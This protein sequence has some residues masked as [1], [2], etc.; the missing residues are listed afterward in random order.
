MSERSI[1][2]GLLLP[3]FLFLGL[4]GSLL[5]WVGCRHSLVVDEAAHLAAGVYDWE[6]A[7]FD[8]YRVNPPLV[9]CT[10]AVPVVVG[11]PE[12]NWGGNNASAGSRP[13]WILGANFL[14]ANDRGNA[15]WF[16]YFVL[17]RWA[18]LPFSV[19]G[20][21]VCYRWARELYGPLAG[22]VTLILWCFSPNMIAW[23]STI[24][25][26]VAASALGVAAGYVFWRWLKNP[27][28]RGAVVAGAVLGVAQL[29]KTTWV[30]LFGLW[31]LIL[32]IWRFGGTHVSR[33]H[34][35]A[36]RQMI[37][38]PWRRD[39]AQMAAI[40]LVGIYAI[41]LGYG[42]DGSFRN[43]GAYTFVSRTLAG[44]NSIANDRE[45]GNRFRD[46]WL[47]SVYV[48]LPEDYVLGIDLQKLDFEVGAWSFLRGEWRHGGWWY[49]YIYAAFVKVPLGTWVLALLAVALSL[50]EFG[51]RA[52]VARPGANPTNEMACANGWRDE[53]VLVFVAIS[54][55][56][57]VSSQTGFNRYFR[58]V[59]P[60]FPFI[61]IW[62]SRIARPMKVWHGLRLYV[63]TVALV[64]MVLSS[65]W[66]FPHNMSYFNEVVGGPMRGHDHLIDANIDWGQDLW[67]QRE[68]LDAHPE[69]RPICLHTLNHIRTRHYGFEHSRPPPGPQP[70]CDSSWAMSFG[71]HPGWYAMSIH[72]IHHRSLNYHYFLRFRPV[73]MVGYSI[74][75]YHITLDEANRF[76]R[77]QGLPELREDQ[78]KHEPK[79]LGRNE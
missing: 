50:G 48:P 76:R 67:R 38:V 65:L 46:H 10:A 5:A 25:P 71:P 34:R 13:E 26:D 1:R 11:G 2:C 73:A 12:K 69:A 24:C 42:F 29:T 56:V 79:P 78:K 58:Y 68:W 64:W 52:C 4:H 60:S 19:L 66:C 57:L 18:V 72:R 9:R 31:P 21:Y 16:R 32:C 43:L 17:A 54:V 53:I 47:G 15:R 39:F 30:V 20:A 61:F 6:F 41:N 3:V 45:G 22:I 62:I 8:V 37:R 74:Y 70:H 59:L 75:I 35:K 51:R 55:F 27:T 44:E 23:G 28:W 49:Y 63:G 77:E 14:R 33:Q 7:R 36:E 40:L